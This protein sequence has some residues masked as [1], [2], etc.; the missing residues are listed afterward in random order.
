VMEERFAH[1]LEAALMLLSLVAGMGFT[2]AG[3]LYLAAAAVKLL[4]LPLILGAVVALVVA[5]LDWLERLLPRR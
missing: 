2:V 3:C 1:R 4:E 5:F